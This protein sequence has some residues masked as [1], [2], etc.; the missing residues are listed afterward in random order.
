[1]VEFWPAALNVNVIY[2]MVGKY[3]GWRAKYLAWELC[4]NARSA[5]HSSTTIVTA[6]RY[7]GGTA[8]A[9]YVYYVLQYFVYVCVECAV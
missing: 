3:I 4:S 7:W 1:M 2:D 8:I 5:P 9:L 6:E